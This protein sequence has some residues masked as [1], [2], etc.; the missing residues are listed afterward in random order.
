MDEDKSLN[1]EGAWSDSVPCCWPYG[2]EGSWYHRWVYI[3]D[4][5]I[6]HAA[7]CISQHSRDPYIW[8]TLMIHN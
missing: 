4:H 3:A 1:L 2:Y 8:R 7:I 6:M 5:M